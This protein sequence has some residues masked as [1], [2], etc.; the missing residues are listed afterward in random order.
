VS[1]ESPITDSKFKAMMEDQL[2][3]MIRR[4]AKND[5]ILQNMLDEVIMWWTL[6]YSN[7]QYKK[8]SN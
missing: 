7:D 8:S 2:W 1:K 6:K 3:E 4:Q 5:P